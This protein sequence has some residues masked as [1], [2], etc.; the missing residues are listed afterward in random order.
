M[1]FIKRMFPP[2]TAGR[3]TPFYGNFILFLRQNETDDTKNQT[4][5]GPNVQ[6]GI[7]TGANQSQQTRDYV[8][9][10]ADITAFTACAG[11]DCYDACNQQAD[12]Q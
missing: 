1:E 7:T 3:D 9:T 10:S 8:K 12:G 11:A 6:I 2:G 4:D 5:N